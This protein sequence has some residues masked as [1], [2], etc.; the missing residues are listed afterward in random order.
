MDI[1]CGEF[2]SCG[3][4]FVMLMKSVLVLR[5]MAPFVMRV[6][7]LVHLVDVAVKSGNVCR[8]SDVRSQLCLLGDRLLHLLECKF[9]Y[10]C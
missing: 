4:D 5:F 9:V 2:D 7:E 1:S 3:F 6:L 8:N 10:S